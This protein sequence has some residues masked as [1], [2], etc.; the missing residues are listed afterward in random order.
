[1]IVTKSNSPA[2]LQSISMTIIRPI[3]PSITY[4][5]RTKNGRTARHGRVVAWTVVDNGGGGEGRK[6]SMINHCRRHR[7]A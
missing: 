5:A 6:T 2:P 3:R 1:M 7:F 4:T